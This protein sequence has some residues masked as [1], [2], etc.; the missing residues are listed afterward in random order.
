MVEVCIQVLVVGRGLE[1]HS[2][3]ESAFAVS[4][5]LVGVWV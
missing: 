2:G 4:R 1:F 3:F 5:D